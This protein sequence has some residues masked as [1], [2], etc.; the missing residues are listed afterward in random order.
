VEGVVVVVVVV[1]TKDSFAVLRYVDKILSEILSTD[2]LN[3]AYFENCS[4]KSR[5]WDCFRNQVSPTW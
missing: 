3:P 5:L 4:L 2:E 1:K